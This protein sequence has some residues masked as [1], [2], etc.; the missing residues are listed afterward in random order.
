MQDLTSIRWWRDWRRRRILDR[1]LIDAGIWS[2]VVESS[3]AASRL[4]DTE[5][6]QLRDLASLFLYEKSIEPAGGLELTD[7]MLACIACEACVPIR[8]LGL[9]LYRHWYSVIVY[10]GEFIARHRYMDEAG[11]EHDERE[12]RMGE[13][14]EHGPVVI[15]WEDVA[16]R[17]PGVNV[18]IHEMAHKLD[19]L[20]GASNGHPPL[21]A[22]MDPRAWADAFGSAYAEHVREIEAGRDTAIDPYAAEDPA[23]FFAVASEAFFD[24]PELLQ[25][26]WPQVYAQLALYYRQR[27]GGGHH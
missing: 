2:P 15:S 20:D 10:P 3:P 11:V 6:W 26:V 19:L 5:R 18:I 25:D 9:E 23:E 8:N 22:D 7:P 14:W 16:G 27:P 24:T 17:E 21:H 1:H 13:A 12:A 4:P